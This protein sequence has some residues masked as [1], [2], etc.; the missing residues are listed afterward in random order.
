RLRIEGE[1]VR[2][3]TAIGD[4]VRDALTHLVRNAI[5]HGIEPPARRVA[6]GKPAEGTITLRALQNGNQV[7]IQVSDDGADLSLSRIRARARAMGR[8]NVH[9]PPTASLQRLT[10]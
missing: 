4:G 1:Q 9:A 8:S 2:V 10:C 6:A 5:D 3:D 7:I